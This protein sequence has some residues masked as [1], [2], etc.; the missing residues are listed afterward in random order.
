MRLDYMGKSISGYVRGERAET[1]SG[2]QEKIEDDIAR[3]LVA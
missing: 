3:F 2:L 1:L